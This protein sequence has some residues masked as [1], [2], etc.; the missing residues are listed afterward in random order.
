MGR[1]TFYLDDEIESR[2]EATAS[3]ADLSI[4]RWIAQLVKERLDEE[5]P[6]AVRESAGTWEDFPP[7]T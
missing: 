5:W 3:Q 6:A 2:L 1:I 4:S 7:A